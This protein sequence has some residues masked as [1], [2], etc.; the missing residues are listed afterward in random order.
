LGLEPAQRGLQLDQVP[1]QGNDEAMFR[2]TQQQV[3]QCHW[4][5]RLEGRL[6][7]A[8]LGEL[9]AICEGLFAGGCQIELDLESISFV[10]RA[11]AAAL[12][13]LMRRGVRVIAQTPFV[14]EILKE[15]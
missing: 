14:S 13:E 11:S 12:R 9:L 6:L 2:I 5:L 1:L 15:E 4:R 8:F 7:V 10:D 3:R